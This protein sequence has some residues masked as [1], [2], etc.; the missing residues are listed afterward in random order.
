MRK[1]IQYY[2]P[3]HSIFPHGT[4]RI[5]TA[6]AGTNTW[7]VRPALRA[8]RRTS[9]PLLQTSSSF[10][11]TRRRSRQILVSL[12]WLP[13]DEGS[14]ASLCLTEDQW[15]VPFEAICVAQEPC[16]V[17]HRVTYWVSR[18]MW[19]K[20]E[21]PIPYQAKDHNPKIVD[22]LV[23]VKIDY[24]MRATRAISLIQCPYFFR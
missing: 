1:S 20:D 4:I 6:C 22:I 19:A 7:S 8:C 10:P 16:E 21:I 9:S 15:P 24:V 12:M 18:G 13:L 23:R 3:T 2:T 14:R 11:W 17:K 5:T